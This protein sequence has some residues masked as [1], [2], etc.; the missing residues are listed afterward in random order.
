MDAEIA[1]KAALRTK[2]QHWGS[3][4]MMNRT[5]A[6]AVAVQP[7]DSGVSA[8]KHNHP[9]RSWPVGLTEHL[10]V[11]CQTAEASRFELRSLTVLA[12]LLAR[13]PIAGARSASHPGPN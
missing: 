12:L 10:G 2:Q 8:P 3:N 1:V 11:W 6:G 7:G 4:D 5:L 13:S 9:E